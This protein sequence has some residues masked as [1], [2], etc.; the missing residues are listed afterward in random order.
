[1]EGLRKMAKRLHLDEELPDELFAQLRE[2]E[3]EKKT[4]DALVDGTLERTSALAGKS[5]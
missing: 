5:S 3:I 2:E 4:K 1:M